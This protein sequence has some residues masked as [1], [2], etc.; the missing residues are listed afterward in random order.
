MGDLDLPAEILNE[1]KGTL[2]DYLNKDATRKALRN[3]FSHFLTSFVNEKNESVYGEK[4]RT[5][6]EANAE[7]L[8]ISF[9]HLQQSSV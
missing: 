3:E 4:I 2:N 1:I 7:S 6:C 9:D 8:V 5:M